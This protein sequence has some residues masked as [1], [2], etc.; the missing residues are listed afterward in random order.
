MRLPNE[1]LAYLGPAGTFS[2]QAAQQWVQRDFAGAQDYPSVM[3]TIMAVVNNKAAAAVVPVENSIEGSV[4]VTMDLLLQEPLHILGETIL[5]INHCLAAKSKDRPLEIIVSHPQALAQ[6]RG[7][8]QKHYPNTKI[9]QADS[10]GR[11]AQ[12]AADNSPGLGA[13]CSKY[14]ADLNRLEIISENLAD[15]LN[16]QTRFLLIGHR[17]AT[18]GRK[19]TG[20]DKTSLIVGLPHD[21]PGGLYEILWEFAQLNINLSRIESRPNKKDLGHYLFY[22]DC[23]GHQLETRLAEAIN[24]LK[25]KASFLQIL[26]SYPVGR[27]GGKDAAST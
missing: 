8:L 26:G 2:H 19:A 9:Q 11:A 7:Y 20:Q 3:E 21:K 24:S 12:M 18:T 1:T 10:T 23:Q 5:D 22:I 27:N 25:S 14:A 6:C 16:N 15:S 13:I 17:K 4:A